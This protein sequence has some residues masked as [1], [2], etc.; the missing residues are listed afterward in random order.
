MGSIDNIKPLFTV[1]SSAVI[2]SQQ[3][4]AK[5]SSEHQKSHLGLLCDKLVLLPLYYAVPLS[6]EKVSI[7][8][9]SKRTQ[10]LFILT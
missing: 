7:D 5:N 9:F 6:N 3:H 10:R 4:Q 2:K 1:L 8:T